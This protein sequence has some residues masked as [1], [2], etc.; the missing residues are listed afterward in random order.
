MSNSILEQAEE[1]IW[2]NARLLERR[3]FAYHFK[4]GSRESVV[5]A[6]RAY[7]NDD[8]GFGN[9]LEP[10][11]RCPDSQPVPVQ[12]AVEFL[13]E[14]GF[15]DAMVQRACDWL[16]TVTTSEGGVPWLLPSALAYPRAWWW[17][18]EENPA[19]SLNPTAA[20]AGLLHKNDFKHEW[21]DQATAYCWS[22]IKSFEAAEMHDTGTALKF[23]YHVP[24][25][26]R[27]EAEIA[28]LVE[29][30]LAGDLVADV[31][32]TN[33]VRKPL[34]WAPTPDHPL[35]RHFQQERINANLEAIIGEQ[36]EDGGWDI[37]FDATTPACRL[38]WRGWVTLSR[39]KTL[40]A[41]GRL[42]A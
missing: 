30:M 18:T 7:Q 2:Q 42:D 4:G 23:L 38:E 36:Q 5:E 22:K 41:Y 16:L 24:D 35:S 8:G 29:I 26:Q 32:D 39:M 19:A 6:I 28:R 25:R 17:K 21:L 1:F 40:R 13:D 31:D 20:I 33:Y 3:R 37:S 12:H 27:A 9:A 34:D 10:D 14:V 11:I 15:D